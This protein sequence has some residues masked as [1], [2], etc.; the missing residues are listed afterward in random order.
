MDWPTFF[1]A[2]VLAACPTLHVPTLRSL[3]PPPIPVTEW[4]E[5]QEPVDRERDHPAEEQGTL[6]FGV[7]ASGIFTNV[8]AQYVWIQNDYTSIVPPQF[9]A[10]QLLNTSPRTNLTLRVQPQGRQSY[11]DAITRRTIGTRTGRR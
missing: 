5:H 1:L 4:P 11:R 9:F 6:V 10:T 3:T 2:H 8:A 7:G